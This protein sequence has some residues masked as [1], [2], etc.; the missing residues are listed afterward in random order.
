MALD[1]KAFNKRFF[2]A[3][4]G[5]QLSLMRDKKNITLS[6]LA[7]K[8]GSGSHWNLSNILNGRVSGS[9]DQ[10]G[11]IAKAL[12]LS[13]KDFEKLLLDAKEAE[14]EKSH[15]VRLK[16]DT[17]EEPEMNEDFALKSLVGNNPAALEEARTVIKWIKQKHDLK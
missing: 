8:S 12:W 5:N 3:Y 1:D 15:G 16:V 17:W 11:R 6:D 14:I 13:D 9:V 4:I 2:S 7:I 10:L